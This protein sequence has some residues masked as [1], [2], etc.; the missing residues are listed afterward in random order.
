MRYNNGL[1]IVMDP[2][3][4]VRDSYYTFREAIDDVSESVSW[5]HGGYIAKIIMQPAITGMGEKPIYGGQNYKKGNPG[6]ETNQKLLDAIKRDGIDPTT[7]SNSTGI[8]K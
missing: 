1:Y 3:D 5:G 7:I 2:W 8:F 6:M 4:E